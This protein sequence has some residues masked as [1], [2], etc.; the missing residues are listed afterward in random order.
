MLLPNKL[1]VLAGATAIIGLIVGYDLAFAVS[2]LVAAVTAGSFFWFVHA[3]SDGKWMGGGDVKLAFIMGLILGASKTLVALLVAFNLAALIGVI[4]ILSKKLS[5]KSLLP[6][7]PFLITGTFV[8]TLWGQR[9]I[10]WYLNL[11]GLY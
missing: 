9:L 7:G 1:I 4:L 6:F 11:V 8:A 5:R 2:S 3:I 10:D